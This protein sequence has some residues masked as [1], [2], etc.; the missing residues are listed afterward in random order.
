MIYVTGIPKRFHNDYNIFSH[1]ICAHSRELQFFMVWTNMGKL[2]RIRVQITRTRTNIKTE[3]Q[4]DRKH[5][6]I[7]E[8]PGRTAPMSASPTE[9]E[10]EIGTKE[11]NKIL[12]VQD[13]HTH[14]LANTE[15][16]TFSVLPLIQRLIVSYV[17]RIG[18]VHIVITTNPR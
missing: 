15:N 18:L 9:V 12:N 8:E 11:K 3:E 1:I 2:L 10:V 17:A 5:N 7:E 14:T 13:T 16:K 6:N 4:R